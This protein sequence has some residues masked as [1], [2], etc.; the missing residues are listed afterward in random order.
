MEMELKLK[1]FSCHLGSHDFGVEG[2]S[3]SGHLLSEPKEAIEGLQ[4]PFINFM[5]KDK[6][7]A[8]QFVKTINWMAVQYNIDAFDIARMVRAADEL[9]GK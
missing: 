5:A 7:A 6:A 2:R 9:A 1:N 8:E 4:L 3:F